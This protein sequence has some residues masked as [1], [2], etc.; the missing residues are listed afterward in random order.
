VTN[1]FHETGDEL[2]IPRQMYLHSDLMSEPLFFDIIEKSTKRAIKSEPTITLITP[3]IA[4]KMAAGQPERKNGL[5][6]DD[7]AML[8]SSQF[9]HKQAKWRTIDYS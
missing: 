2:S 9:F 5:V 4:K 6:T 7:T 1:L 3:V 8:V